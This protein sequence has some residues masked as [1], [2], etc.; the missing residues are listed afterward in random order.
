MGKIT[1]FVLTLLQVSM[2]AQPIGHP[3]GPLLSVYEF[4]KREGILRG[5]RFGTSISY[6]HMKLKGKYRSMTSRTVSDFSETCAVGRGSVLIWPGFEFNLDLGFSFQEIERRNS[7]TDSYK[8]GLGI[9]LPRCPYEPLFSSIGLGARYGYTFFDYL[10]L[11]CGTHIQGSYSTNTYRNVEFNTKSEDLFLLR[12]N[13][14][15]G[16]G[17]DIP[18]CDIL[19]LSPYGGG[20]LRFLRGTLT[21]VNNSF[22][23]FKQ[24]HHKIASFRQ[25]KHEFF[26]TGLSVYFH[27]IIPTRKP[28][29]KKTHKTINNDLFIEFEYQGNRDEWLV[30][31]NAGIS[32]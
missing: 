22:N 27:D 16:G 24:S 4:N 20:G 5:V 26:F 11:G 25:K 31:M 6:S 14:Y 23:P 3:A 15:A 8:H 7:R 30:G 19:T 10:R 9:C 17:I 32:F 1:L 18:V 21:S 2:F 13:V 28:L 29:F 12:S